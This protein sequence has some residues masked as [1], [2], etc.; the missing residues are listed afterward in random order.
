MI[1]FRDAFNRKVVLFHH[2]DLSM[3]PDNFYSSF[4]AKLELLLKRESAKPA[5]VYIDFLTSLNRRI[6][7]AQW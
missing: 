3:N 5:T 6:E 7:K 1:G 4:I 2:S